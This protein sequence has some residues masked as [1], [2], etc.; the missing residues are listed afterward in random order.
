[1]VAAGG[2]GITLAA[3]SR[4][5]PLAFI[6]RIAN[7]PLVAAAVAGFGAGTVCGDPAELP[8][9]VHALLHQPELRARAHVAS[10]MLNRRPAPSA[11]WSAL[12][13]HIGVATR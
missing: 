10:E 5:L 6:P 1:V 12:R 3:L 8:A 7:Q 13:Q 11:A 4:G 9:A 2:S